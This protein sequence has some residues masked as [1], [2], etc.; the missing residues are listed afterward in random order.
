MG[1]LL[2]TIKGLSA[3]AYSQRNDVYDVIASLG[4]FASCQLRFLCEKSFRFKW[5]NGITL[6]A[7]KG[8]HG[9]TECYYL[10]FYDYPEMNFLKQFLR[11]EDAFLDVGANVGTYSLLAASL[12]AEAHAFEPSQ[13]EYDIAVEIGDLNPDLKDRIKYNNVA[14]G[15]KNKIV[16]MTTNL[17]STTNHVAEAVGL[18]EGYHEVRQIKLDDYTTSKPIRAMKIDVEDYEEFVLAGC[19]NM[20][21]S[22]DLKVVVIE[23][24]NGDESDS[25]SLMKKYGFQRYSYDVKRNSLV[26]IDN[27]LGNN[28]IYIKDIEFVLGRIK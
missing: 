7:I 14:V 3:S 16:K 20:L 19:S 4:R 13:L 28:S 6:K 12:G 27:Q 21:Q 22:R 2:F 15:N 23:D 25:F 10:G 24:F 8:Q 9:T 5:D 11:S 1:K 17:G 26:N 18:E